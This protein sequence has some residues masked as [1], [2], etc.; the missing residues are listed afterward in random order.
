MS[1][2]LRKNY[3]TDLRENFITDEF[4]KKEELIKF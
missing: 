4:L 1:A 3:R 2:T